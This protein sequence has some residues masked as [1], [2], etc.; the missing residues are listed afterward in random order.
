[1]HPA[2]SV[3]FFT[4]ASGAGYGLLSWFVLFDV[5]GNVP[6]D[7][8]VTIVALG[9][10]FALIIAGLL[11]S[12]FHL[13]HPER[14][15]RA[16]S[17]WRTSW[18]SR[19]GVAAV[20]TFAP[21]GLYGLERLVG[22][23]APSGVGSVLGGVALVCCMATVYCTAMIYASL[24]PIRAWYNKWTVVNYLSLSVMTGFLLY[25]ALAG[26]FGFGDPGSLLAG[27]CVVLVACGLK[28]AYWRFVDGAPS[29]SSAQSATG[30]DMGISVRLLEAPHSQANYLM[31]EMVFQVARKHARSLRTIALVAGFVVPVALIGLWWA[32]G[33]GLSGSLGIL[34][35]LIAY[36]GVYTERWLFFA[37]AKHTVALYYGAQ[38]V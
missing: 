29:Q 11:S 6:D 20:V 22:D 13:G 15:W 35:A 16:L 37:E 4:T 38:S 21:A 8:V 17:Q 31:K 32:S 27:A 26:F 5:F 28:V 36:A 14:A 24:K 18:L 34:A 23:A 2:K 19:E 12:T 33:D 30:L 1:M 3:I 10:A 9:L 25:L 7:S